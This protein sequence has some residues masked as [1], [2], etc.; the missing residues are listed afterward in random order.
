M[1]KSISHLLPKAAL[2]AFISIAAAQAGT[3]SIQFEMVTI[4]GKNYEIGKC[5][6][7]QAEWQSIMGNNPSYFKGDDLPVDSVSWND[8]Q[9]FLVRLNQKAGKQ[10]RLPTETEWEYACYGGE[11]TKYCGSN[12]IDDVAWY[13]DNSGGTTHP[14]GQ[15]KANSYGLYD[16]SGNVWEWMQGPFDTEKIWRGR[17]LRG[18][19]WRAKPQYVEIRFSAEPILQY[20]TNGFRLARTLP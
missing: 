6:V 18:G 1:I 19:A 2:L 13:K 3:P 9:E 4:P 15:K 12:N 20:Y 16:M 14:T 11:Q 17:T 7:T 10:Y 5:E 8:I